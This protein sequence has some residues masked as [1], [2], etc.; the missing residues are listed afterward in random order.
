VCFDFGVDPTRRIEEDIYGFENGKNVNKQYVR[1]Q[2]NTAVVMP[3]TL[4]P[5]RGREDANVILLDFSILDS[6]SFHYDRNARRK[7]LNEQV[8]CLLSPPVVGS[9]SL[10]RTGGAD[11]VVM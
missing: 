3:A 1:E 7:P 8:M 11:S 5:V 4:R 10:K 6:A 2:S 9:G